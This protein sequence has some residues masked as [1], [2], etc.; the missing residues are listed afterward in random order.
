MDGCGATCYDKTCP[1]EKLTVRGLSRLERGLDCRAF[2]YETFCLF[3]RPEIGTSTHIPALVQGQPIQGHV[4]LVMLARGE[5]YSFTSQ[6]SKAEKYREAGHGSG[7][8]SKLSRVFDS[9]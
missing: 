6:A 1:H 4:D 9:S 3:S 5:G 2:L 8:S 7:G